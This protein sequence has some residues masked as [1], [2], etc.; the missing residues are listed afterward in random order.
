MKKFIIGLVVVLLALITAIAFYT[1]FTWGISTTHST[2]S[3]TDSIYKTKDVKFGDV[4]V[5]ALVADTPELRSLGLGGRLGLSEGQ[6]ML[7]IFD[8]DGQ[9]GFWMKDMRF[10]IDILWISNDNHVIYMV[11]SLTPETYPSSFGPDTPTHYVLEVPAG[12]SVAHGVKI[13]DSISF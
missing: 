10:P 5:H 12:Y 7:F 11:Q 8:H 2:I 4:T 6:G 3:F 13:G 9:Y 1:W